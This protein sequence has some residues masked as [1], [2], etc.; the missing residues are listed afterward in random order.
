MA[1]RGRVC[2]GHVSEAYVMSV[3]THVLGMSSSW[4]P[5]LGLT[6]GATIGPL[7][8]LFISS[9]FDYISTYI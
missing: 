9:S 7:F 8:I 4:L 1:D 3:C 5:M 6:E 2:S